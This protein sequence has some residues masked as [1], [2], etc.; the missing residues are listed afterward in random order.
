MEFGLNIEV[1]LQVEPVRGL[2]A[3]VVAMIGGN[4]ISHYFLCIHDE[5]TRGRYE[6]TKSNAR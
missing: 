2:F 3:A 6:H 5:Q 1:L 4:F